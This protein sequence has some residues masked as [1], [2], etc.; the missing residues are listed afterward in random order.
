MTRFYSMRNKQDIADYK[1]SPAYY[2]GLFFFNL[3]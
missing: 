3:Q 2:A 1:N